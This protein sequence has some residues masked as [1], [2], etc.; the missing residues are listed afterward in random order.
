M[1]GSAGGVWNLDVPGFFNVLLWDCLAGAVGGWESWVSL[2]PR[3][4]V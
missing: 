4:G 2:G 3:E 1:L